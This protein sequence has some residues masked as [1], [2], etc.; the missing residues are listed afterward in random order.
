MKL[1]VEQEDKTI[2]LISP[3]ADEEIY[4]EDIT[5]INYSNL[6]GEVVTIPALLNKIGQW[7]ADY[8]RKAREAKL[9]CDVY[10]SELKRQYRRE[11]ANNNG[12]VSIDDE[13]FKL[14]EKGL[15]ELVLLNDKYQE[16]LME[17]IEIESKRDKLDALWWATK[18]KDQKLNNLLPKVTPKEFVS[19]LI[20]GKINS[21]TIVK[22]K[23]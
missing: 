17:Q 7:K 5:S 9:Y 1:I 2:V 10:V 23:L 20:E 18:S 12:K 4:L 19:E 22:P 3:D 6:Y 13:E 15:D 21:F 14:T 16:Y 11:A 8:E